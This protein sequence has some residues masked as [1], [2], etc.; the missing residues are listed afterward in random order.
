M[1]QEITEQSNAEQHGMDAAERARGLSKSGNSASL[2]VTVECRDDVFTAELG[3]HETSGRYLGEK[4]FS[5]GGMGRILIAFD[6]VLAREVVIKELLPQKNGADATVEQ[7]EHPAGSGRPGMRRFL[8]EARI[9]GSLEHPSIVPVY[10]LGYRENGTPYYTMKNVRGITLAGA[11]ARA[12]TL[13]E[14]LLLLPHF[15][16]LCQAIAYAHSRGVIHRDLKP[17]NIMIGE[18]GETVVL[19][20]GLARKL[21][22][23]DSDAD[24]DPGAMP[25]A[26]GSAEQGMTMPGKALGTPMYMSPEQAAGCLEQMTERT[27]VYALGVILYEII[28]GRTPYRCTTI[29]ETLEKIGRDAPTPVE[30]Y[31]RNA[32]RALAAVCARAMA[33]DPADRYASAVDL[34]KEITR[35]LSGALVEAYDYR[36]TEQVRLFVSRYKGRLAAAAAVLAVLLGVAG[37]S[38]VQVTLQRNAATSAR[39]I[40]EKALLA[41]E[42]SRKLA[43]EEQAKAERALKQEETALMEAEVARYESARALYNTQ[44]ALAANYVQNGQYD[45]ARLTL[46]RCLPEYRGWEWGRLQFLCNQDYQS[47]PQSLKM[48]LNAARQG[49]CANASAG[50]IILEGSRSVLYLKQALTGKALSSEKDSLSR[51]CQMCISP[52][53]TW[54][55]LRVSSNAFL[56]PLGQGKPRPPFTL[57]NYWTWSFS[58]SNDDTTLAVRS[59][60]EEVTVYD[61][62][63]GSVKCVFDGLGLERARLSHDGGYAAALMVRA[64]VDEQRSA[65][66]TFRETVSGQILHEVDGD[67]F[68]AF[69]FAPDRTLLVAGNRDGE[70]AAW[71]PEQ[72]QPLWRIHP[73]DSAV[74][75]LAFGGGA[76]MPLVA[77]ASDGGAVRIIHL[78]S[79]HEIA[80]FA[81]P[82][83][84]VGAVALSDDGHKVAVADGALIHIFHVETG[85]LI[86]TLTGHIDEVLRLDFSPDRGELLYS[87][88]SQEIKIWNTKSPGATQKLEGIQANSAA[89][90]LGTGALRLASREGAIYEWS[91]PLRRAVQ[92][93]VAFD[94]PITDAVIDPYGKYLLLETDA[95]LVLYDVEAREA[96]REFPKGRFSGVPVFSPDGSRLAL[97]EADDI[98]NT[99]GI[100]V[101]ETAADA[102]PQSIHLYGRGTSW[103]FSASALFFTPDGNTLAV[104]YGDRI[105]FYAMP[106]GRQVGYRLIPAQQDVNKN[107]GCYAPYGDRF[108]LTC[109]ENDLVLLKVDGET[110]PVEL[111]ATGSPTTALAFNHDGTRLARG[112]A[113]GNVTLYDAETGKQMLGERGFDR[114]VLFLLFAPEHN[115]LV[116]G[117]GE[118]TLLMRAL[119]WEE[120]GLPGDTGS[121]A[122]ERVQAAKLYYE[123]LAPAW[124]I[125]QHH[126]HALAECELDGIMDVGGM[127]SCPEGGKYQMSDSGLGML[128]SVHGGLANPAW[129]LRCMAAYEKGPEYQSEALRKVLHDMLPE[130]L[131]SLMD[132]V[133]RWVFVEGHNYATALIACEKGL[134][135]G[136]ESL[137]FEKAEVIALLRVGRTEEA[138]DRALRLSSVGRSDSRVWPE[139]TSALA[140]RGRPEDIA[141][142]VQTMAEYF[143]KGARERDALEMAQSLR[144]SPHYVA[145]AYTP[146]LEEL[147]KADEDF[148]KT[149]P[150]HES[151]DAALEAAVVSG[152]PV[153]ALISVQDREAMR[154]FCIEV[155]GNPVARNLVAGAHEMVKISAEFNPD[156]CWRY[157]LTRLPAVVFLDAGARLL[158]RTQVLFGW[159]TFQTR[160][161]EA[162]QMPGA[163]RRWL[164][165]GPFDLGGCEAIEARPSRAQGLD[166]ES[167]A[168]TI[169]GEAGWAMYTVPPLYKGVP[170]DTL[171]PESRDKVF[172][173]YACFEVPPDIS[174][175]LFM[176]AYEQGD[177]WLDGE[178][179]PNIHGQPVASVPLS[180]GRHELLIKSYGLRQAEFGAWVS[181]ESMAP[182]GALAYCD[183]PERPP[184]SIVVSGAQPEAE[185]GTA[186]APAGE[187][188]VHLTVNK[189]EILREWRENHFI[190]LADLDP[191]I[192][193]E[194]GKAVGILLNHPE[195][196]AIMAAAG[197]KSGDIV[198][199]LNGYRMGDDKSILEIAELTEG[200]NPYI[201]KV[202]RGKDEY[203][204]VVHVE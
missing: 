181:G 164:V 82:G 53:S 115:A 116:A 118:K 150:W 13:R 23:T 49:Y 191:Q 192:Y 70:L 81:C 120:S 71:R 27:D 163:I 105:V 40:A 6:R 44:I 69:E 46:G 148:W 154:P 180:P 79:G 43:E 204:L 54:R 159:D 121:P 15:V 86:N 196:I 161:L 92:S 42:E 193:V 76:E 87:L 72:A 78:E 65:T 37:F 131:S 195:K 89:R 179:I 151:L 34:S 153:M 197:M 190:L 102:E 175:T 119:P 108:V 10:E 98:T 11:I 141:T 138:L 22:E 33:K 67:A 73:H 99:A 100:T 134:R 63:A 203:T 169:F 146:V 31:E 178:L 144:A 167:S 202:K 157:G 48:N 83:N 77:S 162:L 186:P 7:P 74:V 4:E 50:L 198:I 103:N 147:L 126:M 156:L 93:P 183:L 158:G 56:E 85:D 201:I 12:A 96:L 97:L 185:S 32:P 124:G 133:Y 166:L 149:L 176:G 64:G 114:A 140:A 68:T 26:S 25:E 107:Y 117:D 172:Y 170:V 187:R 84:G 3:L 139:L 142:A 136:E 60:P 57:L 2:D 128:C 18:Y 130:D 199:S 123:P 91:M 110:P 30:E 127:E 113:S 165:L 184:A 160:Y 52:Q 101:L 155:L 8:R 47:F 66:L 61:L 14:R 17:T 55:L 182:G 189:V 152:K 28:T 135:L 38:Y 29:E 5:R 95:G 88:S 168:M 145:S 200:S 177:A 62:A 90:L 59:A 132:L 58:F 19:D 174:G 171:F 36:F 35:F 41:E 129:F 109:G 75:A 106:E 45:S 104:S 1:D 111:G 194:D 21:G 24:C 173:G 9:T 20:W 112:D 125:C 94:T 188:E 51:D 16:N 122:D 80:G 39:E 137:E 143:M